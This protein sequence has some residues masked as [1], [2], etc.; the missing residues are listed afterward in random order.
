[1][2]QHVA[3]RVLREGRAEMRADAPIDERGIG[4]RVALDRQATQQ[5]EAA[6]VFEV[7]QNA[8]ELSCHAGN[9]KVFLRQL[10]NPH[11]AR[12]GLRQRGV[13]FRAI[14]SVEVHDPVGACG[15]VAAAPDR[16][17]IDGMHFNGHGFSSFG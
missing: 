12:P 1:M 3:L 5:G 17:V 4:F 9:R 16:G 10:R 11:A 2:A 8:G 15:Q 14:G 6:A 7:V 13:E